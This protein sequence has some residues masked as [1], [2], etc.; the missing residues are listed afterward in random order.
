MLCSGVPILLHSPKD[1]YLSQ[2]ARKEGFAYVVDEEDVGALAEAIDI[3]LE[4]KVLQQELVEKA[5]LFANSRDSK[6]WAAA[7]KKYVD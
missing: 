2:I 4:D 6:K 5:I 3:L 7:F 1:S